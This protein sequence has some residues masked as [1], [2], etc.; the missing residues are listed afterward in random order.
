MNP[1]IEEFQKQRD[2]LEAF[3]A[4]RVSPY[5]TAVLVKTP[6]TAN[7]TTVL[8]GVISA[9]NSYVV[10]RVLTGAFL[11]LPLIQL[12]YSLTLV[13]DCVD[14]EIARARKASNPVGG[15]LLDGICHRTTEYSLLA[16]YVY[17]ASRLVQS[18]WVLPAGLLL[19]S[20]EA[21]YTY[22]YER[23]LTTL[24][25]KIG[26]S[27]LMSA[28]ST[29][30]YERHERWKDFSWRRRLA[31]FK[32]QIQYKSIYFMVAL[33]YVSGSALLVGIVLLA[34]Y[35]HVTWMRLIARTL[36]ATQGQQTAT[37][38]PQAAAAQAI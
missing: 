18:P 22:A 16:V 1:R 15:K 5:V 38:S 33:A 11:W 30:M 36:E 27:G 9:L 19:L 2:G 35:K 7:Q 32:G 12:V 6:L 34:V 26:F 37:D 31:T 20:G 21:M 10:Y 8:W 28:A 24:R 23:R 14:G 13:L 29:N 4:R 3:W 25:I 17:A